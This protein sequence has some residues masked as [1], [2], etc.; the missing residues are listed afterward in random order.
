MTGID[1]D[2]GEVLRQLME[3]SAELRESRGAGGRLV[4]AAQ[5]TVD[6]GVTLGGV[7]AS[8]GDLRRSLTKVE[9]RARRRGEETEVR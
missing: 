2:I 9:E 3:L 6:S 1:D 8:L 7:Q 4:G 5:E